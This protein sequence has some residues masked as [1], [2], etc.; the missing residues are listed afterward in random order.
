MKKNVLLYSHELKTGGAPAVLCEMGKILKK[1]YN[2]VVLSP[3]DGMMRQ[4]FEQNGIEVIISGEI[5]DLLR[6]VIIQ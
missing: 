6:N 3:S 4:Q 2:V 5:T 1:K